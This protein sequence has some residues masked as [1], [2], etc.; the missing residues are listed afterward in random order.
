MNEIMRFS[1][2]LSRGETGPS[3]QLSRDLSRAIDRDSAGGIVQAHR[4][5]VDG[6]VTDSRIRA[7]SLPTRT[8]LSCAGELSAYEEHLIRQAP[9][10]ERRYQLLVDSFTAY[11]ANELLNFRRSV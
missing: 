9:L 8:A 5:Q 1:E 3:R 6:Y 11:A 4:A 2:A 10:G 7:A